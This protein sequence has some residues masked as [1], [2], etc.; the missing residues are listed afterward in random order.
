M[1]LIKRDSSEISLTGRTN[2]KLFDQIFLRHSL[3][4]R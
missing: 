2:E 4:S 1:L 3:I